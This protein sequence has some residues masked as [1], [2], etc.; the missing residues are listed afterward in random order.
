MDKPSFNVQAISLQSPQKLSRRFVRV[1]VDRVYFV[2]GLKVA[3]VATQALPYRDPF[4]P[5]I[6][7]SVHD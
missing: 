4:S 1:L 3:Y 7:Q 2:A 6:I 5:Q